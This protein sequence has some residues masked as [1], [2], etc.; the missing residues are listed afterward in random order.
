MRNRYPSRHQPVKARPRLR[1]S[2]AEQNLIQDIVSEPEENFSVPRNRTVVQRLITPDP[3]V[4]SE[5]DLFFHRDGHAGYDSQSGHFYALK[6]S[7]IRF[8]SYYN[9]FP[10]RFFDLQPE[11]RVE[12]HLKAQ[13]K[14]VLE[15]MLA[16]HHKSWENLV[17]MILDADGATQII[18]L[19]DI[20]FDGLI[21]A[22]F[23]AI[24]DLT[25]QSLDYV[26]TGP[27]RN[28]VNLTGVITTFK[29]DAAVQST[30]NRLQAYFDRN[31]DLRDHF[32]LLVIDNGGE[33]DN[34]GFSKG[35][36][37]KNPNYGGAGGFSRGLLEVMQHENVTHALFMD[38]D[39]SFFPE[40]LRRTISI[41]RYSANP[42]L[43]ISGAMITEAHKWQMWEN[44]AIFD[45]HCRPID[46]RRDLRLFH[47]VVSMALAQPFSM[48][49]RYGGWWYFCFPVRAVQTWAFPFFVRGDD[50]Y[51]SLANDF[52]ILTAPGIVSHQDDFSVKQSPLTLYLDVRNH[53]VQHLTFDDLAISKDDMRKMLGSF[54]HR[55]NKS[56]HYET[57][58]AINMAIADVM[59]GPDF[60]ESNLD[61]S[62]RRKEIGALTVNEK[63]RPIHFSHDET[64]PHSPHR[65]GSRWARLMRKWSH[66]GHRLPRKMLYSKAVVFPLEVRAIMQDS[67]RRKRTI[68]F[69][70][71]SGLGYI[72]EM[73]RDRY[74]ANRTEFERNVKRL[75]E[76]YEELTALYHQ[77]RNEMA[78]RSA[79]EK[80]FASPT[81]E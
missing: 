20:P 22:R 1:Y 12:L 8:D 39:A 24:E 72:C 81:S 34:I 71:A 50:I 13:G 66:N 53:I 65:H 18:E 56:F 75:M 43:A 57:A 4:N 40:S 47:E 36:V 27:E 63:I 32:S 14:C 58:Q 67:Y 30:S 74:F 16:R 21:Y 9:V 77:S 17:H 78:N 3:T 73:D 48:K 23:I 49:N 55:Y 69:D 33:T 70:P 64:T 45:R 44:S 38:D 28:A 41:L 11:N 29:R 31:P 6:R 5:A 37:I 60:W 59:R 76:R 2:S 26:V 7:E 80:R 19:P 79:W 68:T 54:F 10:A 62:A 52:S 25:I 51:F 61:M 46:N 15:V 42:R 35:R